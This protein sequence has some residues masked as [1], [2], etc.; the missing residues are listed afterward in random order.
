ML[1]SGERY[2]TDLEG[3]FQFP[4]LR[5]GL[6]EVM[7]V[8]PGCQV[9]FTEV[10]LEPWQT[11]RIGFTVNWSLDVQAAE[12]RRRSSEGELVTAEDIDVMQVRYLSDVIRRMA[13]EMVGGGTT[14]ADASSLR[15]RGFSSAQGAGTPIL[16]I[17]GVRA[18]EASTRTI[19]EIAPDAVAYIEIIKGAA[20]GWE[21]GSEGASGVI[22]ITTKSGTETDAPRIPPELCSIPDWPGRN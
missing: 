2:K 17:D 10:T 1:R 15:G 3:R 16:V 6:Q 22:R 21:F 12:A 19:D 4:G 13:P 5:P 11:R 8:T 18:A 9:S 7:I 14:G 20:G